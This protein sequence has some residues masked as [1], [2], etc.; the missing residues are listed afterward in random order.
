MDRYAFGPKKC[1]SPFQNAM[2]T[3][4]E[5]LLAN[6]LIYIDDIF[7]FLK[8]AHSHGDLLQQ[9]LNIVCKHGNMLSEKKWSLAKLNLIF[10]G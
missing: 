4:F 8:D 5:R 10:S 1:C 6:D 9:F 7:L 2:I 3:I